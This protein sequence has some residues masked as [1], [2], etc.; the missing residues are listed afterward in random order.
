MS[1]GMFGECCS[2]DSN[3]VGSP[4]F[5]YLAPLPGGDEST[6]LEWSIG[7]LHTGMAKPPLE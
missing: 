1:R 7:A 6:A 2:D 5:P 4:P 3:L